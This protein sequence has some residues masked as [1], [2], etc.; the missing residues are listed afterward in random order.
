MIE[1]LTLVE[2]RSET[3]GLKTEHGLSFLLKIDGEQWLFDAGQTG[4]VVENARKLGVNLSEIEG[5][6]LSHGHYDHTG[7]LRAVLQK[8]GPKKIYA[9]PDIF[10]KRYN[11]KKNRKF[12]SIGFP[13]RKTTVR[14]EGGKFDLSRERRQISPRICLSGEI[15]FTTDFEKGEPYLVIREKRKYI[16]DPFIDEQYLV[17]ESNG[18]LVMINGCCHSGLIN[19]LKHLRLYR[20]EEKIKAIIGGLHL[21]S[22]DTITLDKVI[23]SLK[24]FDPEFIIAGHCTGEAAESRLAREFGARFKKLIT[25]VDADF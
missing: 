14:K 24:E 4:I 7:G 17:I 22:A 20:P 2:E 25:G 23:G 1:I 5:I 12:R 18:G 10:R 11:L 3:A 19:S 15:P 13:I 9:H 21:R 8:S 6:I 16:P